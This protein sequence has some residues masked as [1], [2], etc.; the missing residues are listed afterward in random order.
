MRVGVCHLAICDEFFS[1]RKVFRLLPIIGQF[2]EIGMY[3]RPTYDVLDVVWTS[4]VPSISV[5]YTL[6]KIQGKSL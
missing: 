3:L 6:E 1:T 5:V 2:F 4:Y